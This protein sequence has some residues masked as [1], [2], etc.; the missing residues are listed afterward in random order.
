MVNDTI[1]SKIV[2]P[3]SPLIE[4]FW[5]RARELVYPLEIGHWWCWIIVPQKKYSERDYLASLKTVNSLTIF[6]RFVYFTSCMLK[7]CTAKTYISGVDAAKI[8]LRSFYNLHVSKLFFAVYSK[9]STE[10]KYRDT[11]LQK[12]L[13]VCS[14]LISKHLWSGHNNGDQ[15]DRRDRH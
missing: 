11:G 3:P 12:P 8:I 7:N 5:L 10:E 4:I 6:T 2:G 1:G 15:S 9:M 14:V 13:D